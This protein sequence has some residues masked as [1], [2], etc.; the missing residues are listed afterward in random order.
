[1]MRL[2]VDDYITGAHNPVSSA[3]RTNATLLDGVEELQRMFTNL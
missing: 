2:Y 1:M 3:L